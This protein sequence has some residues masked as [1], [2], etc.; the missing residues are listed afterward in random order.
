MLEFTPCSWSSRS[1]SRQQ[2]RSDVS[3]F[4]TASFADEHIF[5]FGRIHRLRLGCWCCMESVLMILVHAFENS[6]DVTATGCA[7]AWRLSSI[8]HAAR[9]EAVSLR[10]E[11]QF[12]A[13]YGRCVRG[14]DATF[15]S[16]GL[17][18]PPGREDAV[19][20]FRFS[21]ILRPTYSNVRCHA[22]E[23]TDTSQLGHHSLLLPIGVSST[24]EST[25]TNSGSVQKD[26]G[27]TAK[28]ARR[29]ASYPGDCLQA[30]DCL[31]VRI[32]T[33]FSRG[34]CTLAAGATIHPFVR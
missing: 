28:N 7:Y 3:G 22:K 18:R 11:T 5:Q 29:G 9:S 13:L 34:G 21:L 25:F 15:S 20:W 4:G 10:D 33:R 23:E 24:K 12:I 31:R 26:D 2:T 17:S 1:Q 32:R 6:H 14:M 19:A 8:R 27:Q 30:T 16:Q